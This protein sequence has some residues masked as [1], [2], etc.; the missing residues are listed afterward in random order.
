MRCCWKI[1]ALHQI[2]EKASPDA[3]PL[4]P[5]PASEDAYSSEYPGVCVFQRYLSGTEGKENQN[6]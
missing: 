2:E 1:L 4:A 3:S 5:G 6:A